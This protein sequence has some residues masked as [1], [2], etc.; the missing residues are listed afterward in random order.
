MSPLPWAVPTLPSCCL[1]VALATSDQ[2]SRQ[3]SCDQEGKWLNGPGRM[4]ERYTRVGC[5]A[6]RAAVAPCLELVSA[7]KL[8]YGTGDLGL[9]GPGVGGEG[10][11]VQ[12]Q[13]Y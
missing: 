5:T 8:G 9:W 10:S 4:Q 13:C 7:H 11:A 1:P 12:V 3:V 6:L 2:N